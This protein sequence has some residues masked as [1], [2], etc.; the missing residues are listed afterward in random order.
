MAG[1]FVDLKEAAKIL[2]VTAD[3][4]V[5][6]RSRGE[7]FGYRDGASW[8]FKIEEVERVASERSAAGKSGSGSGVLALDDDEFDNLTGS[9]GPRSGASGMSEESVDSVLVSED[10]QGSSITRQSTVI[11]KS[12]IGKKAEDSDLKLA[13][14]TDL[15]GNAPNKGSISGIGSSP[16]LDLSGS[17]V[18][19]LG[20]S[21]LGSSLKESGIPGGSSKKGGLK[22]PAGSDVQQPS[23]GDSSILGGVDL[24]KPGSG[25]GAMGDADSV[26]LDINTGSGAYALSED[27]EDDD[28]I[29]LDAAELKKGP[30]TGSDVT[31]SPSDSG[32]GIRTPSDSGLSL[33]EEPL[34]L[35]GSGV[36]KLELPEDDDDV[37]SLEEEVADP[38]LATQLKADEAFS[39]SPASAEGG[40]DDESDSGSQVIALEDSSAFDQTAATMLNQGAAGALMPEGA[41]G[42]AMPGFDMNAGVMPAAVPGM[43]P[44]QY[45]VT[46]PV[47][48]PYSVWNVLGL[49]ATATVLALSG[50]L[51]WDV[52]LNLWSYDSGTTVSTSLMEA[53]IGAVGLN[54]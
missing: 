52:V 7:I 42:E 22:K 3:E 38:D 49:M 1:K 14:S 44:Q 46:A 51:M 45:V 29:S 35:G 6:M 54:K 47:E 40:P 18:L 23:P 26:D 32:I 39:L 24:V 27:S 5:E 48:T 43:Q 41:F 20:D 53:I 33:D 16:A 2:G 37:I 25:T 28:E 21:R 11:G 12:P 50:M 15:A 31:Y 10:V 19:A 36:D 30:G 4:L 13:S 17:D 8:K 9:G 34:D